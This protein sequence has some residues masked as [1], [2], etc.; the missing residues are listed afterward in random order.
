MIFYYSSKSRD[1]NTNTRIASKII[2]VV[3]AGTLETAE[4]INSKDVNNI[5]GWPTSAGT[6]V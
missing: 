2:N 6:L 5:A 4:A 1:N 3:T